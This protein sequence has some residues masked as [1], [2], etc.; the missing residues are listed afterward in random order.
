MAWTTS[1][2]IGGWATNADFNRIEYWA[3]RLLSGITI[4]QVGAIPQTREIIVDAGDY[5]RLHRIAV[6][7]ATTLVSGG[8]YDFWDTYRDAKAEL[9]NVMKEISNES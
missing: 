6:D 1:I 8:F 2:K 9:R 5:Y 4:N 7:T 3:N